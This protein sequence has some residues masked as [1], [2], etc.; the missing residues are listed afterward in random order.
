MSFFRYFY[1]KSQLETNTQWQPGQLALLSHFGAQAFYVV[2][3]L[4]K[5]ETLKHMPHATPESELIPVEF[6]DF[7]ATEDFSVPRRSIGDVGTVNP[8]NLYSN[9]DEL[10]S[11][12]TT[13]YPDVKMK[14]H[15]DPY[16]QQV[17][18]KYPQL[19]SK[20][21][22]FDQIETHYFNIRGHSVLI[23]KDPHLEQSYSH[24][25]PERRPMYYWYLP[26]EKIRSQHYGGYM[27][28]EK[29]SPMVKKKLWEIMSSGEFN[30]GVYKTVQDAVNA[31][32]KYI[33]F[34]LYGEE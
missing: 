29:L 19:G 17:S 30:S 26:D 10:I 24:W 31:A 23:I 16:I 2:K 12:Q 9:V 6:V 34:F 4:S 27:N 20:S 7:F 21:K 28:N 5:E 14:L 13:L 25:T 15:H 8:A 33:D 11:K 32:E 3:I 18:K 1:K 22:I